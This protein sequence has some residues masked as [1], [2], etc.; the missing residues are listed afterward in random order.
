MLVGR[1][2]IVGSLAT[3]RCAKDLAVPRVMDVH[4]V[5]IERRHRRDHRRHHRHR[6]RVVVKATVEAQQRLVDH[7]VIADAVLELVEL[8]T[9][10]QFA[11][12]Q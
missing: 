9:G 8:D 1:R 6:M 2:S 4:R 3:M 11:V 7:R 12:Q 5:V 10:R